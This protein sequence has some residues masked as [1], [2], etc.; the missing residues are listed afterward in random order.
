MNSRVRK[1]KTINQKENRFKTR[2]YKYFNVDKKN[3][4]IAKL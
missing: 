2:W 4:K 1:K 3:E